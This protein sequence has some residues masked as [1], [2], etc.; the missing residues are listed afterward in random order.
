MVRRRSALLSV[1]L[2][3]VACAQTPQGALPT[4]LTTK[5]AF[6]FVMPWDDAPDKSAIDVSFL[7]SA[8]AGKNGWIVARDGHFFEEKTKKRVRFFGTNLGARAA[9]PS[10]EDA[11]KIAARLAKL[12]VNI[13]RFH[14]LNNG[15]DLDGGSVW[16]KDR[17]YVEMDPVQLDKLDF[18]VNELKKRGIY[19]NMNLQTAR[20]YLPEM[21]FPASVTQLKEFAKKIDKVD[22]RMIRLQKEYAKDLIGRTNPY[23]KLSYADDP[24]IMVVEINNENSLVGWPGESPGAGLEAMPPEFRAIVSEKWNAWLRR[25]YRDTA[26]LK[27]A[28]TATS[29]PLGASITNDASKWTYEN[30]SNGDVQFVTGTRG[31]SIKATIKTNPGPTWHVQAHLPGLTLKEGQLYT[32]QFKAV[33]DRETSFNVDTRLDQ[34]DWRFL[35]LNGTARVTKTPKNYS[36]VFR[37]IGNPEPGH[38]RLSFALGDTRGTVEI[39]D[40]RIMPG[41]APEGLPEGESIER[42]TVS[43]PTAGVSPAAK[44]WL[45]FLVDTEV[46]Y[47]R[48]MRNYIVG[49]LGFTR[50]NIIDTQISWGNLTALVREKDSSFADNHAY[51]NHPTF[52]NGDWSEKDY[53]VTRAALVDEMAKGQGFGGTLWGLA[54]NRIEGKPY[55]VSEYNHPAPNDYQTEMMPLYAAFGAAQDWDILYTFDW[56]ASGTGMDNTKY[57]GYFDNA[58]NPGKVAFYPMTAL[59]FRNFAV[60]AFDIQVK[61]GVP[62]GAEP[63][64]RAFSPDELWTK[65]PKGTSPWS[66]RYSIA[67]GEEDRTIVP[68][69]PN[70][71]KMDLQERTFLVDAPAARMASGFVSGRTVQVGD[72]TFE[73]G[74]FANGFAAV[75]LVSTDS[76]P[77]KGAARMLL[78]VGARVEN[79]GMGWNAAR[80]SVSDKWGTGPVIAERVPL[81]LTIPT[82]G[83]RKVYALD[84]NGKRKVELP[85]TYAAGKLTFD[86]ANADSMWVEI[87]K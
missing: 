27:D 81:K 87:T 29:E 19:S 49:F 18:F 78:T 35:G 31:P 16:K 66:G 15:W 13:V 36:F 63:W 17:V 44:D 73:F 69:V 57:G 41:D 43:Q 62:S 47:G 6:P 79:T 5:D 24:A 40:V 86:T 50:A 82:D 20:Q 28:W 74:P 1:A 48:Q 80:D 33:A 3:S 67:V 65:A 64:S 12:G 54:A 37:A 85:S 21:G 77:L 59:M 46:E 22:D 39:E 55:S 72:T 83:P 7:N 2:A 10:K 11:P 45:R 30:Q 58:L 61:A 71:T 68:I 14:H 51:W 42:A 75:A 52:T 9:F 70:K 25:K 34:A 8:P 23:T 84:P 56:G 26:T 60:P 32:V 53:R 76:K 4:P 38:A